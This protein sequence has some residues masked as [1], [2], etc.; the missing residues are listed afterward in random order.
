ME[1]PSVSFS[2]Y[3]SS[4]NSLLN[5]PS[6]FKGKIYD[7]NFFLTCGISDELLNMMLPAEFGC[8]NVMR[9]FAMMGVEGLVP[10]VLIG[11]LQFLPCSP[12]NM[13]VNIVW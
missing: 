2:F 4:L 11:S 3:S 1:K 5:I 6:A 7:V 10:D 9:E 13:V 8:Q 12:R